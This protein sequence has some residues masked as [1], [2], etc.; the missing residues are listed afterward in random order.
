MQLS[1]IATGT[2]SQPWVKDGVVGPMPGMWWV[3][4]VFL[5]LLIL[6]Y[7]WDDVRTRGRRARRA[8]AAGAST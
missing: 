6:G 1:L 5:I 4:A 2:T 7:P 8:M 3:D